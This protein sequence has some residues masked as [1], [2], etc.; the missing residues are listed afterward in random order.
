[1]KLKIENEVSSNNNNNK[2]LF[3]PTFTEHMKNQYKKKMN[4]KIIK[5]IKI[6]NRKLYTKIVSIL[7]YFN[8]TGNLLTII[9]QI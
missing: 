5:T 3:I 7:L 8:G 2:H 1:M 6:H 4:N 9:P